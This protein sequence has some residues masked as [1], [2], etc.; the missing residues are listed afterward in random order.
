MGWRKMEPNEGTAE[1]KRTQLEATAHEWSLMYGEYGSEAYKAAHNGFFIGVAMTKRVCIQLLQE[2]H[3]EAAADL[4]EDFEAYSN[5]PEKDYNEKK[6]KVTET[7]T[8]QNA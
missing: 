5:R 4:H 8:F 3:S 7:K 1:V 2:K 6:E